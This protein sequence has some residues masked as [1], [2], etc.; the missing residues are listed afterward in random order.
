MPEILCQV[1]LISM[2]I[3]NFRFVYMECVKWKN[4]V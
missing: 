2:T 1:I 3:N 4:Y